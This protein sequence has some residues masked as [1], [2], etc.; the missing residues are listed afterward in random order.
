MRISTSRSTACSV[1]PK[2]NAWP[3]ISAIRWQQLVRSADRGCD[4]S[5]EILG[6]GVAAEVGS[7]RSAL[8]QH[9]GDR[10]LDGGRRGAFAKVIEHH[11]ARPDLTDRVGDAA[12]GNI[13]R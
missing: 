1:Y 11:R 2:R 10:P 9:L 6:A 12:A 4:R 5:A 13:R 7:A 8:G 3:P